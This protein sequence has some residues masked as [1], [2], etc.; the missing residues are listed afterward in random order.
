MLS[1]TQWCCC[2]KAEQRGYYGCWVSQSGRHSRE[3]FPQM[4]WIYRRHAAAR[5]S[6][7]SS[8]RE[9]KAPYWD[10]T[11]WWTSTPTEPASPWNKLELLSSWAPTS[12][13]PYC[14]TGACQ[15]RVHTAGGERERWGAEGGT[16]TDSGWSEDDPV[17]V[18]SGRV[19]AALTHFK[20]EG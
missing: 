14:P 2:A 10:W 6:S 12:Q 16:E 13:S 20:D 18:L 7:P 15:P 17:S 19:E 4:F 5:L 9:P 3:F 1:I 8:A 11:A